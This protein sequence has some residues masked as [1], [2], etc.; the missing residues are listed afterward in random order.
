MN[1]IEINEAIDKECTFVDTRSPSEFAVDHIPGAV[2]I[3]IFDDNQRKEIGILYKA[4]KQKAFDL[5]LKYYSEKLPSLVK[6]LRNLPRYKPVVIY[7]WRGGMRSKAITQAAELLGYTAFQLKGGY[8]AYRSFLRNALYGYKPRF[9]FIVLWGLT[10]TGKT[11][12]IKKQSSFIDLEGL[13]Q[14]R[15]SLFGAVGLKPRSQKF[16][17][18]L[19]YFELEKLKK[20]NFVFIEGESR[21]IG[22][23]ILPQAVYKCIREGL[24]IKIS[25]PLEKRVENTINEYVNENNIERIKSIIL[26]LKQKLGK[27]RVND[28][29]WYIEKGEFEKAAGILLEEYYDPLYQHTIEKKNYDYCIEYMDI[30]ECV[31]KLIDFRQSL[32]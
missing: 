24:N 25:C 22:E 2:N 14:H 13:A 12:L 27:K 15:G 30:E 6:E 9:R 3:P 4:S 29:L 7:C 20:S 21:K 19:L 17:E 8:K 10:G 11:R 18:S 31:K 5:G 16:F 32:I 1:S 23:V 28:I 26:V